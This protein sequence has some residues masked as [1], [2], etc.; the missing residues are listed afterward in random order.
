MV[1]PLLWLLP[2]ML[3]LLFS[4]LLILLLLPL[5]LPVLLVRIN[6]AFILALVI[7]VN[8][9]RAQTNSLSRRLRKKK[10][11]EKIQFHSFPINRHS[12]FRVWS[13]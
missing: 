8:A 11:H 2:L 6:A 3:L 9:K 13:R 10:T 1:P 5:L 12:T 7:V 4:L